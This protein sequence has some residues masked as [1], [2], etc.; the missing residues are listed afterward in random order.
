MLKGNCQ[1]GAKQ[2]LNNQE[3]FKKANKN[4]K[5]RKNNVKK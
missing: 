4:N 1:D 3:N 2:S 5:K